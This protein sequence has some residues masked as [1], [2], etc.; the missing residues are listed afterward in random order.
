MI[1]IRKGTLQ[2]CVKL[3]FQIPEFSSPYG[4]DEYNHRCA[5]VYL[6]LVA[7]LD[8]KMVGFKVGYDRFN[9]ES[10]YSWMGGVLPEY[11]RKGIAKSLADFQE[12]WAKDNGYK[13]IKLKTRKK[14]KAMVAFSRNRGFE[15]FNT[16]E[17]LNNQESRIWMQKEL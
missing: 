3:S 16:I 14:H 17:K 15:I 6:A 12:K 4:I 11:R 5:D 1:K 7:E 13:S 10:F 9:D 8:Q 2:E